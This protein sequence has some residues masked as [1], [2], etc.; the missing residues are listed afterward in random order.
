[1]VSVESLPFLATTNRKRENEFKV[2]I[3]Q[4]PKKA[5]FF[6]INSFNLTQH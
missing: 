5:D 6:F 4:Y 1:M 2:R 3:E